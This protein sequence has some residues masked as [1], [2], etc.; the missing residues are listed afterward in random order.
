MLGRAFRSKG[1]EFEADASLKEIAARVGK[2]PAELYK[3]ILD[4]AQ[5]AG[6]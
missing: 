3:L 4:A 2:Q 5:P 6:Q 1:I